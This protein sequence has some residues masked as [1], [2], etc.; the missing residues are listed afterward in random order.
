[1]SKCPTCSKE[2]DPNKSALKCSTCL[3]LFHSTCEGVDMRGFHKKA[4]WTC[5]SCTNQKTDVATS[6]SALIEVDKNS[7]DLIIQMVINLTRTTEQ[8]QSKLDTVILENKKLREELSSSKST[9]KII[10]NKLEPDTVANMSHKG[11]PAPVLRPTFKE[12]LIMKTK[13]NKTNVEMRKDIITKLNPKLFKEIKVTNSR[14]DGNIILRSNN[15]EE[16]AKVTDIINEQFKSEIDI[17][18]PRQRLPRLKIKNVSN[19]A[20]LSDDDLMKMIVEQNDAP[21]RKESN[22]KL[23]YKTKPTN[24]RFDICFEMDPQTF[25]AWSTRQ[26][27]YVGLERCKC[28]EDFNIIRC[29]R[30]HDFG[31]RIQFCTK[32]APTCGLCAE[33]HV[34][35]VCKND[36]RKCSNCIQRNV[37]LNLNLDIAHP[38]WSRTCPTYEAIVRGVKGKIAYSE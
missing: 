36:E 15:Y 11:N 29:F 8:M 18:K 35:G 2:L 17:S 30:C 23:I 3:N 28:Y 21:M 16:L 37:K 5:K 1:M 32:Q 6:N 14:N 20:D 27:L 25:A 9:E 26:W 19:E 34:T 7:I 22:I 10:G 33:E 24:K 12:A 38:T 13:V 4:T 31:H